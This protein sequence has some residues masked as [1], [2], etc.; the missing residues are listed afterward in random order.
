MRALCECTSGAPH[1]ADRLLSGG[2]EG[3]G[4][5]AS[6]GGG[7]GGEEEDEGGGAR[8]VS[9]REGG[10]R[11]SQGEKVEGGRAHDSTTIVLLLY[12]INYYNIYIMAESRRH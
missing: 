10:G 5:G 12:I 1:F 8:E 9:F 3:R 4:R 6:R 2:W 7:G 11:E